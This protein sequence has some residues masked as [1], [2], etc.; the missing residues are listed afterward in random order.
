[1]GARA[2]RITAR[3]NEARVSE[4]HA[5]VR[6]PRDILD[7]SFS[8]YI[9][10][11]IHNLTFVKVKYHKILTKLRAILITQAALKLKVILENSSRQF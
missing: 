5:R 7:I 4:K 9:M 2:A 1:M 6:V 10:D 8:V 3:L 11:F